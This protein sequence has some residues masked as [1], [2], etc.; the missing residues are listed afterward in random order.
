MNSLGITE[1]ETFRKDEIAKIQLAELIELFVAENF[2]CAITL[3]GASEELF[4]G[5]VRSQGKSPAIEDSYIQIESIQDETSLNVMERKKKRDVIRDW[6]HVKNRTK[7]HDKD[8]S[9]VIE[10]NACDEAY[11]L[12]KRSLANCKLLGMSIS[13]ENTFE[14][15]VIVKACL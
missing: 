13:N 9:E 7:H 5:L 14:N 4:A 6:N 11:W 10:F 2:I 8:E 15:W 3:A 1:V 12:I